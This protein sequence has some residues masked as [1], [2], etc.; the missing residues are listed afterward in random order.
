[1]KRGL[2]GLGNRAAG[3]KVASLHASFSLVRETLVIEV[4]D[5]VAAVPIKHLAPLR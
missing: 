4:E 3:K 5:M 2:V 1:M